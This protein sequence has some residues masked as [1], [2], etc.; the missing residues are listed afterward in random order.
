[1]WGLCEGEDCH[2][3][4]LDYFPFCVS[5][6]K[7]KLNCDCRKTIFLPNICAGCFPSCIYSFHPM[8]GMGAALFMEMR[9][10]PARSGSLAVA[11]ILRITLVPAVFVSCKPSNSHAHEQHSRLF[12]TG[13]GW[14]CNGLI[15]WTKCVSSSMLHTYQ[16]YIYIYISF[17][18]NN[19]RV[20]VSYCPA[21]RNAVFDEKAYRQWRQRT[22]QNE[23]TPNI[24][25]S[26]IHHS[27]LGSFPPWCS[28]FQLFYVSLDVYKFFLILYSS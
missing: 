3:S 25:H 24:A 7:R 10:L 26:Y 2:L 14:C 12:R 17:L 19:L 18:I 5:K 28:T 8:C 15:T 21:H 1:M 20:Q 22:I 27:Q 23:L 16:P 13:A 11:L 9:E 4:V 6:L